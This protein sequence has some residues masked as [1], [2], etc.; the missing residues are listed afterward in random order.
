[1]KI[2]SRIDKIIK[3]MPLEHKIGQ[4]NQ[5]CFSA[6]NFPELINSAKKGLIGSLILAS[7]STAGNTENEK[8]DLELLNELQRASVEATGI[9]IINGRDVIHGHKIV[10]PIPLAFAASFDMDLIR[11]GYRRIAEEAANDG[12]HWTFAPMLDVARDPRWGR[13]VESPGEDTY[14]GV[15]IARAVVEGF[16]GNDYKARNSIAACAKHFIGYGAAEG[17]RDYNH[18]EICENSLRNYYLPAFKSAI[19]AGVATVMSA[20]N[21]I[22]GIPMSSNKHLLTDVLKDELGFDGF[23]ISDWGAVQMLRRFGVAEDE[24]DSAALAFDAG[25]DMDMVDECYINH[26]A[27]LIKDGAIPEERLNDA[28]ARI[29]TV[30]EKFGLFDNPYFIQEEIDYKE[31]KQFSVK[32]AENSMVL[33][34]NENVLPLDK[35]LKIALTGPMSKVKRELLGSWTLDFDLKYV[36]SIQEAMLEYMPGLLIPGGELD[37][38]IGACMKD[39]DVVVVVIGESNTVTGERKSIGHPKVSDEQ[40]SLIRKAKAMGK[41]VVAVACYGRP[42]ILTEIEAMCDAILY[43]WHCGTGTAQAITRIL[44]GEFNP[45]AKLPVTLPKATG[46]IPLYYNPPKCGNNRNSYYPARYEC[47][48]D[49]VKTP[50]YSFGYGLSYSEFEYSEAEITPITLTELLLGETVKISVDVKNVSETDGYEVVQ[51]Y[52]TDKV[53]GVVRSVME[54]KGF[55]KIFV[56]AGKTVRVVFELS[57]KELGYYDAK[58]RF[59][60]DKGVFEVFTGG[61]CYTTNKQEFLLKD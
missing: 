17:G 29:L 33:L 35:N 56:E 51:C 50:L 16:Q 3:N 38:D 19:D 4:L 47:Y 23:V 21:D 44:F 24:K 6:D 26:I 20:F 15:C 10:L 2:S 52:I 18:T 7:S 54:L 14:L 27:D 53:A 13:C 9:P 45:C 60:V 59:I 48:E 30:K 55:K 42:I 40:V 11:E 22:G 36:E 57:I 8:A 58:N 61:D 31:H 34:K 37:T 25:I 5:I 12:I 41:K 46:Q 49:E 39:S 28:V 32:A 43:A 1:M